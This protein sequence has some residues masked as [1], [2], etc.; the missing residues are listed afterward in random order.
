ML[1]DLKN[2]SL[3]SGKGI[4]LTNEKPGQNGGL[5][6]RLYNNTPQQDNIQGKIPLEKSPQG[7]DKTSKR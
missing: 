2:T 5:I 1:P 7:K 4:V 6:T 3:V